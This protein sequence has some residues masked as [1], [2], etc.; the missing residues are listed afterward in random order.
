MSE[1]KSLSLVQ[2]D[3]QEACHTE[4]LREVRGAEGMIL[5]S[6]QGQFFMSGKKTRQEM[7]RTLGSPT[8]PYALRFM[9]NAD[10]GKSHE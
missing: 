4:K 1:H 3:Q 10:G 7:A 9:K 6:R 2:R 8:A 5:L